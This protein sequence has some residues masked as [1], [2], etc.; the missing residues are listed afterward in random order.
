MTFLIAILLWNLFAH[1]NAYSSHKDNFWAYTSA[2]PYS[3]N[4]MDKGKHNLPIEQSN[5]DKA[6]HKSDSWATSH[7]ALESIDQWNKST[8]SSSWVTRKPTKKY[9]NCPFLRPAIQEQAIAEEKRIFEERARNGRVRL[10]L[11]AKMR[12]E[13]VG[14]AIRGWDCIE[15]PPES[16]KGRSSIRWCC[17]AKRRWWCQSLG[18]DLTGA[19]VA[20]HRVTGSSGFRVT[21]L[22]GLPVIMTWQSYLTDPSVCLWA[23]SEW[24]S[25]FLPCEFKLRIT[26]K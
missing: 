14:I 23:Y 16:R 9:P 2:P 8:R 10:Y 21:G 7:S 1:K 13:L 18:P 20:A 6:K 22:S 15:A 17:E 19:P 25:I 12:E 26:Y 3:L 4:R 11:I 24:S 5:L